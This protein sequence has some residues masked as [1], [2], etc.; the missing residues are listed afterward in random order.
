M[1]AGWA[2][3][4]PTFRNGR[5]KAGRSARLES[6]CTLSTDCRW[7]VRCGDLRVSVVVCARHG[8][9]V[10]AGDNPQPCLLVP[11]PVVLRQDSLSAAHA[12]RTAT[13]GIPQQSHELLGDRKSTRLNSSH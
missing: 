1:V 3:I 2:L 8:A 4:R 7:I 11:A 13:L 10:C 12:E 6:C 9:A 5:A